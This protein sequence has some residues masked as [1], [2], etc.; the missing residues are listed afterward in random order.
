MIAGQNGVAGRA[1][2]HVELHLGMG[3][4]AVLGG[5]VA[6][7][8]FSRH[9]VNDLLDRVEEAGV[10]LEPGG[11]DRADVL[12]EGLEARSDP[13]GGSHITQPLRGLPGFTSHARM[14]PE[15]R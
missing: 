9:P 3:D 1:A 6:P 13:R 11:D 2:H 4:P 7:P 10:R 12:E 5:Y 15:R 8:P 14:M